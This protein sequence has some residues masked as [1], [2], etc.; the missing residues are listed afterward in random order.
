SEVAKTLSVLYPGTVVNEDR[1]YGRIHIYATPSEQ[2]EIAALIRRL[3]GMTGGTTVAVI[4][5][6]LMDTATLTT[7]LQALFGSDPE[8]SPS[9]VAN[10]GQ[11]VVRGTPEQVAQVRSLL[12]QMGAGAGAGRFGTG[13]V[14]TIPLGSRDPMQFLRL[15]QS[16]SPYPIRVRAVPGRGPIQDERVPAATSPVVPQVEPSSSPRRPDVSRPQRPTS[17]RN[18]DRFRR[19][20]Y[21]EEGRPEPAPAGSAAGPRSD[22]SQSGP[23][24]SPAADRPTAAR[25]SIRS[26]PLRVIFA[27]QQQEE[28]AQHETRAQATP[29]KPR[30]Q[31]EAA[32]GLS[33]RPQPEPAAAAPSPTSAPPDAAKPRADAEAQPKERPPTDSGPQQ[34]TANRAPEKRPEI[35]VEV[36]GNNLVISSA[37]EKALDQLEQW[38]YMLAQQ[39]PEQTGWTVFYLRSADATEAAAMLEQLFPDSTVATASSSSGLIGS[40][41]RFGSSVMQSTGLSNVAST[42][43]LQIIPETRLNALFVSGPPDKVRDVENVLKVLDASELPEQLRDRAPRTIPVEYADATQVAEIIR[44]VY[45]VEMGQS[46]QSSARGGTPPGGPLAAF[47]GRGGSRGGSRAAEQVKLTLGVDTSTNQIIVSCNDSLYRQIEALVKELDQAAYEARQTV[48]VV[49]VQHANAEAVQQAL[50]SMIPKLSITTSTGTSSVSSSRTSR[51]GTPPPR[52]GGGPSPDQIRAFFLQ[53]LRE[54]MS[55]G[56]RSPFSRGSSGFRPPSRSSSRGSSRFRPPSPFGV[57]PPTR[58]GR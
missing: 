31:P 34:G 29:D 21:R 13:R 42:E 54:R 3:D 55:Q 17:R 51:P 16:V 28:P 19:E 41:S 14:R 38:I 4:P 25:G 9:I 50:T 49:T 52:V 2:R 36:Q 22:A 7:T 43:T 33:A 56:G 20:S 46:Q 24:S 40:L 6:G 27:S 35:V 39:I 12:E 32:K 37:D 44:S 48:R 18:P 45:A 30:R 8:N 53:R 1:R 47:L 57:R 58:R 23:E 26:H 10:P 15:L 5:T 11:L